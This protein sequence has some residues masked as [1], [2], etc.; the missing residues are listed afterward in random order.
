M[1]AAVGGPYRAPGVQATTSPLLAWHKAVAKIGAFVIDEFV[2][3]DEA[4]RPTR[5]KINADGG[6]IDFDFGAKTIK[7]DGPLSVEVDLYKIRI[8]RVPGGPYEDITLPLDWNQNIHPNQHS[9]VPARG[10]L[11]MT[12]NAVMHAVLRILATAPG[13][14]PQP[15]AEIVGDDCVRTAD[16][17]LWRV[18]EHCQPGRWCYRIGNRTQAFAWLREGRFWPH[19]FMSDFLGTSQ[20][21]RWCIVDVADDPEYL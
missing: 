16:G 21:L 1:S 17:R 14:T 5:V 15:V 11:M 8:I 12:G 2:W 4:G 13:D 10:A 19:P 9:R 6:A 7:A 18:E 20:H 3:N